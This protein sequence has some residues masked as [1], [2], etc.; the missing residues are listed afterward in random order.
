MKKLLLILLCLPML[1]ST[2][3]KEEVSQ[4]TNGSII[5]LW[6]KTYG[7][8]G[9]IEGYYINYPNNKVITEYDTAMTP[10]YIGNFGWYRT[11]EFKNNGDFE[12]IANGF[13]SYHLIGNWHKNN[14]T[15][16]V[17][18]I[19]QSSLS[20]TTEVYT[21]NSLTSNDLEL[22][23]HGEDTMHINNTIF[24]DEDIE[25]FGFEK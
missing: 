21:I 3:K 5:G 18:W 9:D 19:D 24:F 12:E 4:N 22:L 13:D 17:E 20:N 8:E 10:L 25:I 6:N 15:L 14:N 1:F 16:T 2:C 7:A 11:M 23:M